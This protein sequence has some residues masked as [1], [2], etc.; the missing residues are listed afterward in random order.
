MLVRVAR[1]SRVSD[2]YQGKPQI[3]AYTWKPWFFN[4]G[5]SDLNNGTCRST[6]QLPSS[7]YTEHWLAPGRSQCNQGSLESCV[8]GMLTDTWKCIS[9][10]E[11]RITV[12]GLLLQRLGTH[13]RAQRSGVPYQGG[14]KSSDQLGPAVCPQALSLHS[15]RSTYC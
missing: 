14:P 6:K 7:G 11:Q 1:V 9:V 3:Q 4:A 10:Q 5:N 15:S 12:R 13:G 8:Q 2:F